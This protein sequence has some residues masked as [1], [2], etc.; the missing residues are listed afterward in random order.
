VSK[1]ALH[2][3]LLTDGM[4]LNRRLGG[5]A[6]AAVMAHSLP[7]L[8]GFGLCI[9]VLYLTA[10]P[11]GNPARFDPGACIFSFMECIDLAAAQQWPVVVV[12]RYPHFQCTVKNGNANV[13]AALPHK[14]DTTATFIG[15]CRYGQSES[16]QAPKVHDEVRLA[17]AIAM[18]WAIGRLKNGGSNM[19]SKS[20][21]TVSFE[22]QKGMSGLEF[23]KGLASGALPLNT[24]A[25][26]M[27]YDVVQA[28][29]GRVSIT[30][31]PTVAH[32]NPW[33]TIHG[34]LTA[35]LLDSCMGLAIKWVLDKGVGS[36]TLEFKISFVQ[37]I[38]V[39]TGQLRAEGKV[40]NCGSRVGTAEGRLTDANGRLLAH[41]TTTCL[42]LPS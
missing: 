21:G 24:F 9:G 23:V 35:T 31:T 36:T 34:G 29:S 40:I 42:I 39:E 15:L 18:S 25:Y 32:L 13:A 28:E 14:A 37:A 5:A 26:T 17:P 7:G 4:I 27:G 41:G 3:Q 10:V 16:R 33:G 20:Y 2:H 11:I 6:T 1:D 38:T 30:V 8:L 19:G 12:M 22:Q